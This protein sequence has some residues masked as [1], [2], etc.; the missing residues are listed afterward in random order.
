MAR[1]VRQLSYAVAQPACA[2]SVKHDGAFDE[3]I[4]TAAAWRGG[5]IGRERRQLDRAVPLPPS[6]ELPVLI[7]K[8]KSAMIIE[9]VPGV[10]NFA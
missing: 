3:P 6:L 1:K 4:V 9:G 5:A 10:E 2:V 8:T 7:S